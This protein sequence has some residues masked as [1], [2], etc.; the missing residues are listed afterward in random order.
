MIDQCDDSLTRP[1]QIVPKL[2]PFDTETCRKEM[3]SERGSIERARVSDHL[4]ELVEF[5]ELGG[6]VMCSLG[7]YFASLSSLHRVP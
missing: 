6:L 5:F 7:T 2:N 3:P 4:S 1:R